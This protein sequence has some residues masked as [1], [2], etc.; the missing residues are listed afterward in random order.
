VVYCVSRP[1]FVIGLN[2]KNIPEGLGVHLFDILCGS[3]PHFMQ[4]W[5]Q[6]GLWF[7]LFVIENFRIVRYIF[8]LALAALCF[9]C[10]KTP[11]KSPVTA[12]KQAKAKPAPK[13]SPSPKAT[14]PSPA[15]P[16]VDLPTIDSLDVKIGQMILIGINNATSLSDTASVLREIKDHKVGGIVLFEKNVSPSNSKDNLK[17]LIA[18]LQASANIP[19][20]I[21]IDEE[22]GKVH[23]LK[24]KYGFIGMPSAAY[25]GKLDRVDSTMFYTARLAALMA[26]LGINLNF[27]PDVDLALNKNNPVIAK[28]ERSYSDDPAMVT[29]HALASIKTHHQYGVKTILK[30]FPGHGSSNS[31][32]HKGMTD[33]TQLWKKAE[34][35]PYRNLIKTGQVDA[36]MTAHIINCKLDTTCLPA[37]L[38]KTIVNGLLRNQLNYKGVVCSDD[39]QMYAI[40]KYYGTE[41]AIRMA[42]EAG[43]DLLLFG[44]NVNPKDVITAS[45]MHAIIKQLVKSGQISE[46]RIDGSFRRIIRLKKL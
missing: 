3:V 30:H 17:K 20:F 42:I 35:E 11:K 1:F 16:T 5:G 2:K 12:K 36:I 33:V 44:N 39:M 28:I 18:T 4:L 40:S 24:E 15:K 22:G 8:V 38:S 7:G 32:T 34:L 13:A 10:Q 45:Q 23:R 29:K 27:A 31:D 41:N 43:V 25:L 6:R 26:D 21:T 9:T 46:D 14:A 37:T 19:L